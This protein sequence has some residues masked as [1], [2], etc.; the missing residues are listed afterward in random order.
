MVEKIVQILEQCMSNVFNEEDQIW[1]EA[2]LFALEFF[3]TEGVLVEV[4]SADGEEFGEGS[5]D[6]DDSS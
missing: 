1:F 3:F 5:E 2:S 4:V 6:D